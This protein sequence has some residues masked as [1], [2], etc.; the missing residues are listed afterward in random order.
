MTG[1]KRRIVVGLS[2]IDLGAIPWT[3]WSVSLP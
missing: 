2:G 3:I 1:S